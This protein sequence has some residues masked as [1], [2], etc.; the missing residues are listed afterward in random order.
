MY[1]EKFQ[2]EINKLTEIAKMK[3]ALNEE[4]IIL[5][6]LKYDASAQDIEEVVEA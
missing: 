5:R 1:Q 6:L 2:L 3:G 4:E